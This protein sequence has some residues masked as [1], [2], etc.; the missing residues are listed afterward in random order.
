VIDNAPFRELLEGRLAGDPLERLVHYAE[1]L[2]TW[3]ARHNLVHV[4]HRR[5]LVERHLLDALAGARLLEGQ[6]TLVDIGSGAGL[7][8]VPLLVVKPLWRGVLLEPR[9]KRWAFLKMVIRELGLDARAVDRRYEELATG[10]RFDLV[11]ARAVG[12]HKALLAWARSHLNE[13]GGVALWT[14]VDGECEVAE[15][16]GWRVLSWPLVGLDRGRLVS[17]RK[18]ST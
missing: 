5:E 7:P 1:L 16:A 12:G 8:G 6:G 10:E 18:R 13:G 15:E 4:A 2:E 9:Q 11:T 17:L 3:S 14:T